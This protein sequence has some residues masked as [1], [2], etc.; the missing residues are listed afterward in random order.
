MI[1]VAGFNSAIDRR[2]DVDTL[3][4]GAVHRALAVAAAPGGKG[5]NVA[6]ALGVLGSEVHLVGLIDAAQRD[7]FET[8]LR[9]HGVIF[10]GIAVPALRTCLAIRERNGRIT[11]LLEPGPALQAD[12]VAAL[13]DTFRALAAQ[14]DLAVLSGSLPPGCAS[15]TYATLVRE[16][17][18]RGVRCLVDSSGAALREALTAQPFLVKPNRD[19]AAALCGRAI[20]STEAA[21]ELLQT[22]RNAGVEMPVLSLGA[23]GALGIAQDALLHAVPPEVAARN[24]VGSGDCMLAGIAHA[25]VRGDSA[26][27]A[28]RLGIACGAANAVTDD[29]GQIEAASVAA[30]LPC[31]NTRGLSHP[32]PAITRP[33]P[34]RRRA[35]P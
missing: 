26:E 9:T 30:L 13:L 20:D 34:W 18:A 27:Q 23:Q 24:P 3:S 1:V 5:V 8:V 11:E 25:L 19:E 31:V 32:V 2:L 4:A 33:Q 17:Q 28:L 15:D 12:T 22:L 10:H 6:R 35:L 21:T 29:T 16:T 7:A 14:A